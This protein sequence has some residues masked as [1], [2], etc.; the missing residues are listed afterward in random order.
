MVTI[1]KHEWHQ[2]DSQFAIEL[3]EDLLSEIY[4]DLDVGEIV[5]MM[6]RIENGEIDVTEVMND[7]WDNNVEIE[8]ERQ[9]DDWWTYRKGGYD[10]TYELGDADSWVPPE[11]PLEPTHKCTNCKWTGQSYDAEWAWADKEGNDLDDPV[12]ICPY[13]ES[14]I[15]LTEHGVEEERKAEERR[16]KWEEDSEE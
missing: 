16:R 7:A 12:K 10:V 1:V 3:D 14:D 8:W 9:Y 2:V 15:E 4:P 6:V 13:C 11:T 5:S